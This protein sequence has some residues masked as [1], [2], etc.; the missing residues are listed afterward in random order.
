MLTK[1]KGRAGWRGLLLLAAVS[2]SLIGHVAQAS[3]AD[4]TWPEATGEV[5]R[6]DGKLY[7]DQSHIQDGYIMCRATEPTDKRLKLRI[8]SPGFQDTFDLNGKGEFEIFPLQMG[9]GQYEIALYEGVGGTKYA[10]A[11][12]ISIDVR[13][14]NELAPLLVPNQYVMYQRQ[15]P[16][17]LKSDELASQGGIYKEVC[18]FIADEFSYDFG[19]A[20]SIGAGALPDIDTCFD[21]RMGICQDLSAMMVCMLRVQGVPARLVIGYADKY[22]HAW[23]MALIEGKEVFYDPTDSIA[24]INAKTYTVERYY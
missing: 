12:K 10:G 8:T 9:D 5:V 7:V 3:S 6:T 22:Y 2:L 18:Q 21:S 23:V 11:G 16:A 17:V 20:K 19:L 1:I 14:Q 13:L 15:T 4:A 24:P